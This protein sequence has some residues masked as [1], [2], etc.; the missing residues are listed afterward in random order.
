MAKK[1]IIL[2]KKGLEDLENE[3]EKLKTVKRKEVA[4]KIKEARGFGDLSENAEYNA[5]KEEQAQV[6]ERIVEIENIL[7]IAIVAEDVTSTKKVSIGSKVEVYDKE[8]DE[9]IEYEIVGSTEADVLNS[10]ISNESPVGSALLGNKK[11]DIVKV[12]T[13][14][15]EIELEIIKIKK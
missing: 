10:K 15:G 9:K 11:G 3:L 8:L 2:T 7:K 6:E 12:E 13:P 4:E 1:E 14:G 5:A